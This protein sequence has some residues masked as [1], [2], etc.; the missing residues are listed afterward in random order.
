MKKISWSFVSSFSSCCILHNLRNQ[1]ACMLLPFCSSS[2]PGQ[3]LGSWT[4]R[5]YRANWRSAW[6]IWNALPVK[7]LRYYTDKEDDVICWM[8]MADRH[9][10]LS[11]RRKPDRLKIVRKPLVNI[12]VYQTWYS[13]HWC[14]ISG[15]VAGDVLSSTET[16][17]A[18][19]LPSQ[20]SVEQVND[21]FSE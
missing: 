12:T 8:M 9:R 21:Y 17:P 6:W 5:C 1:N 20:L 11:I 2:F 4:L 3:K 19:F 16:V 18:E 14:S 13:C 7:L 15:S 10:F